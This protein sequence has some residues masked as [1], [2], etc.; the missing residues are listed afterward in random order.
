VAADLYRGSF[1][2][3][4]DAE[5]V[6]VGTRRTSEPVEVLCA[7]GDG[8]QADRAADALRKRLSLDSI[9]PD[10]RQALGDIARETKIDTGEA[11]GRSYARAVLTLRDGRPRGFLQ[12]SV[13]RGTVAGFLEP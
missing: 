9:L 7:V 13:A 10:T 4:A 6:A 2:R 8:D 12:Q 1:L 5:V 3:S 11:E